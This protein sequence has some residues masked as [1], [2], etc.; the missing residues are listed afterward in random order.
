MRTHSGVKLVLNQQICAAVAATPE[1]P[2][3]MTDL[4]SA[5]LVAEHS[6]AAVCMQAAAHWCGGQRL[7]AVWGSQTGCLGGYLGGYLG[8]RGGM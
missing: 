6:L 5:A 3:H 7:W 2:A 1:G 8:G 4:T